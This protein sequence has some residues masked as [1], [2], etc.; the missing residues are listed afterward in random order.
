MIYLDTDVLLPL[1]VREPES[2]RLRDWFEALPPHEL[3]VSEWTR[4]EFVSAI[5]I[6]ARRGDLEKR[7][8][9]DVV[10]TF[11]QL[12]NDSLLVLVPERDDFLLSSRYLERFDLGLRAGDALHLA[13]ALNHGARELYSLDRLLVKCAQKLKIKAR[14][15]V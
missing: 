15:P 8:A 3:T 5:G 10:R 1:F 9:Q 13:M 7:V 12:A 11:H 6:K 2:D 14:I 4:T